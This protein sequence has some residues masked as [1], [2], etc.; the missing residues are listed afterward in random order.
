MRM[1]YAWFPVK[2]KVLQQ[3]LIIMRILYSQIHLIMFLTYHNLLF[4]DVGLQSSE[5]GALGRRI[6]KKIHT[7]QCVFSSLEIVMCEA[8]YVYI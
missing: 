6:L 8:S 4:A 2:C 1:L 7:Q 3:I 5:V